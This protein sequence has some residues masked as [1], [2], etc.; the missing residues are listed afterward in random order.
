M[1][2][3]GGGGTVKGRD[4]ACMIDKRE[5]LKQHRGWSRYWLSLHRYLCR[6]ALNT[7]GWRGIEMVQEGDIPFT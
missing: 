6:P 4:M 5:S 3:S 7:K 1:G 2:R